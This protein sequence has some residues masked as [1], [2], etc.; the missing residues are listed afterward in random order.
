MQV[1]GQPPRIPYVTHDAARA[2]FAP[3]NEH[4]QG[5]LGRVARL[6]R[7]GLAEEGGAP[8]ADAEVARAH[9][10]V[11]DYYGRGSA[12]VREEERR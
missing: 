7:R 6:R 4:R 5:R 9:A 2:V 10:G 8:R 12:A 11:R 3:L 1:H